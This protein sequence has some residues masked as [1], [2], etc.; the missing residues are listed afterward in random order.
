MEIATINQAGLKLSPI[1]VNEEYLKKWNE[2]SSG[3]HHL[4]L[5]GNILNNN[6]LYRVGGLSKPDLNAD[7]FQLIRYTEDFYS[8][9]ITK[10]KKSKPHLKSEFVIIDKFGAEKVIQQG[11]DYLHIVKDSCIYSAG[12][13]YYNIETDY[14]YATAY[15][16]IESKDYLFLGNYYDKEKGSAMKIDK[17]TGKFEILE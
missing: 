3:F 5:N 7:Y 4:T 2:H 17:K 9:D 16:T 1:E 13:K 15:K 8:D 6:R 10:D 14:H 11:L 12:N